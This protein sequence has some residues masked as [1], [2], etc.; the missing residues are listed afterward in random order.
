MIVG[1]ERDPAR[2]GAVEGDVGGVGTGVVVAVEVQCDHS[3][4]P[5]AAAG[6]LARLRGGGVPGK[7]EARAV[8]AVVL[9]RSADAATLLVRMVG[10]SGRWRCPQGPV[11]RVEADCDYEQLCVSVQTVTKGHNVTKGSQVPLTSH[12][13]NRT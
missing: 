13:N 9:A 7:G 11:G 6:K 1:A 2:P 5:A 4:V 10:P 8:K 3:A 12:L